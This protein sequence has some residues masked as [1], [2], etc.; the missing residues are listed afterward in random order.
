M[1]PRK[2]DVRLMLTCQAGQ[3][4]VEIT[5]VAHDEARKGDLLLFASGKVQAAFAAAA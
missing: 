1:A 4:Q 3:R 2:G 5:D